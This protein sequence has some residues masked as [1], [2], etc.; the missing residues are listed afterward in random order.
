MITTGYP[1]A[2]LE[3]EQIRDDIA[4]SPA[5]ITIEYPVGLM[6]DFPDVQVTYNTNGRLS[7]IDL[8]DTILGFYDQ[9]LDQ[10]NVEAYRGQNPKRYAYLRPG[11]KLKELFTEIKYPSQ[12]N[13][14]DELSQNLGI[15]GIDTMNNI[16][17]LSWGFLDEDFF[18]TP[19]R[20]DGALWLH[21]NL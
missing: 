3:L 14:S 12:F 17:K 16:L 20:D 9:K 6:H 13:R 8:I 21:Q 15:S 2:S 18:D 4:S 19:L 1:D 7:A 5:S 10:S 11:M